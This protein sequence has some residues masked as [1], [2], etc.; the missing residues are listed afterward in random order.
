MLG[1]FPDF[2]ITN[3]ETGIQPLD[4]WAGLEEV[5]TL[6][7]NARTDEAQ[8]PPVEAACGKFAPVPS[9]RPTRGAHHEDPRGQEAGYAEEHEDR[10]RGIE[11][12]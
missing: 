3:F 9:D 7:H 8:L 11:L 6:T 4:N 1:Y 5:E 2:G 10:H 12:T